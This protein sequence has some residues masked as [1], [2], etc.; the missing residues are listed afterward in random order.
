M[1]DVRHGKILEYFSMTKSQEKKVVSMKVL[2]T[3]GNP[4]SSSNTVH[5]A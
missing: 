1:I 5:L 2:K 4:V 3:V